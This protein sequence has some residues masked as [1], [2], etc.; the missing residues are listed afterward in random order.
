MGT[1]SIGCNCYGL[2]LSLSSESGSGA[3][4][5][6]PPAM[7]RPSQLARA[8]PHFDLLAAVFI[9][10]LV[11]MTISLFAASV[12]VLAPAIAAERGWNPAVVAF[13]PIAVYITAILIS[14]SIPALLFR[15]GG[16]GLSLASLVIASAGLL[17]LLPPYAAAATAAS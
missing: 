15:M 6:N 11:Q 12:P 17:L 1:I 8:G 10:L 4:S 14:F 5:G 9:S 3:A 7:S 2:R 13:Y 16:M